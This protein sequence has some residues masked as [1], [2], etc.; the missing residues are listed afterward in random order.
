MKILS[1]I[2]TIQV[3]IFSIFVPLANTNFITNDTSIIQKADTGINEEDFINTMFLKAEFFEN[4]SDTNYFINPTLKTSKPLKYNQ[5]WYMDYIEDSYSTSLALEQASKEFQNLYNN[6]LN[7]INNIFSRTIGCLGSNSE[8]F[9]KILHKPLEQERKFF[10]KNIMELMLNLSGAGMKYKIIRSPYGDY[11]H[12]S[13]WYQTNLETYAFD[14]D[15]QLRNFSY[16]TYSKMSRV[17]LDGKDKLKSSYDQLAREVNNM[18]GARDS[19]YYPARLVNCSSFFYTNAIKFLEKYQKII[20]DELFRVQ[21]G[22]NPNYDKVIPN[23]KSRKILFY[24]EIINEI[25]KTKRQYS[26]IL[27]T[28]EN[29]KITA[30]NLK[31]NQFKNQ[32]FENKKLNFEFDFSLIKDDK[33]ALNSNIFSLEDNIKIIHQ[34]LKGAI[35]LDKFLQAFFSSALVPVFQ[36]RSS[37]IE[38]DFLD[39]I[40]YD[41]ILIDFFGLKLV[42]FRNVV[43]NENN[44]DWNDFFKSVIVLSKEFY[45]DYLRS[46]FDLNNNSYVQGQHAKHGL[47]ANNG[48][49][50]Y[51][52]YFYFSDQYKELDFTLYSA[53][54]NRFYNSNYGKVFNYDF[55]V[56]NDLN[57]KDNHGYIFEE[58]KSINSKYNLKHINLEKNNKNLDKK[59]GYNVFEFQS[60]K[61]D[62]KYRY[63]DFN[64][65]IYNWQEITKDGINPDMQWWEY[66]YDSCSWYNFACHMKNGAVWIINNLPGVKQTGTLAK[67]INAIFQTIYKFFGGIFE[68]WKFSPQLYNTIINLFILMFFLKLIK[69]I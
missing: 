27:T 46:L 68:M 63:Y 31:L 66:K 44:V 33:Y 60:L 14:A 6:Y 53:Y 36:N 50:I 16:Y 3:A 20:I 2:V 28:N 42:D 54:Q 29:N 41:T 12:F 7:F 49:K 15:R 69:I 24:M 18:S 17:F 38:S 23:E 1:L 21:K 52:R 34:N 10:L 62:G 35:Y 30:G 11:S 48:F 47:L 26:F 19:N 8:W 13:H 45:K 40:F 55:S 5:K 4:W 65:G 9:K 43:Q 25:E 57:I 64:F 51:P 32:S 58:N 67:G 61:L 59:I 22:G 37:F 56:K 39:N